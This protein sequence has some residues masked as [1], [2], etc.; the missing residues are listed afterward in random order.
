MSHLVSS[1]LILSYLIFSYAICPHLILSYLT[2]SCPLVSCLSQLLLPYFISCCLIFSHL[3]LSYWSIFLCHALV[4]SCRVVYRV[5]CL[6]SVSRH[7]I[8]FTFGSPFAPPSVH[9]RPCH[10]ILSY[11]LGA[12]LLS[13]HLPS[14]D[15]LSP[16]SAY[17]VSSHLLY[18]I[19]SW[20]G[21]SLTSMCPG[22]VV[23]LRSRQ[24]GLAPPCLKE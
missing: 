7:V 2:L 8:C 16:S 22:A 18:L 12:S 11:L 20:G 6:R 4:P 14:S 15:L 17:L 10:L 5:A 23:S 21:F 19:P 9:T 13:S 1:S 3:V 24:K